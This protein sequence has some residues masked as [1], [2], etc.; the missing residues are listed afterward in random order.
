MTCLKAQAV[1]NTLGVVVLAILSK[2]GEAANITKKRSP[3]SKRTPMNLSQDLL[4]TP[5][6]RQG[7]R[8]D[9]PGC[10]FYYKRMERKS[11]VLVPYAWHNLYNITGSAL[12]DRWGW[13]EVRCW[14]VN[15][16]CRAMT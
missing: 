7:I 12:I 15:N 13:P 9:C 3:D 6:G 8:C 5:K 11:F 4:S 2:L 10:Q 14:T 16:E 1:V